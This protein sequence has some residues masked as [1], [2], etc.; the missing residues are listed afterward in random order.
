V[1][2]CW[3]ALDEGYN[4]ASYLIAIR[5]LHAKVW[6]PKVARVLVVG[7][8]RQ[9]AIWMWSMWRGTKNTIRGKVVASPNFRPWCLMN[10]SLPVARP[11]IKSAQT[12]H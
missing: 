12:M 4:F 7:V 6:A 11:S 9:K 8:P 2:Y 10:P 5:G 3:K 1:T